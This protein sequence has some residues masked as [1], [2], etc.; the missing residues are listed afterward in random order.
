MN[1]LALPRA[2]A[3]AAF[4]VATA[5][6]G[7]RILHPRGTV[8][9][10]SL[11]VESTGAWGARVLDRPAEHGGVV[12]LSR[13][14]GLPEPLP[15]I[16]GLALRLPGLGVDGRPLDVLVVSAVR[17][18]FVPSGISRTWSSILPHRTAPH[19]LGSARPDRGSPR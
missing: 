4:G 7:A 17:F 5:I 18:A 14:V 12:R 19:R 9:E 1:I 15:D 8:Y 10:C 2:G 11:T 13:S 16:E 3:A 6:R